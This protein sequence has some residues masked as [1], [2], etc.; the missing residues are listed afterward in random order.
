MAHI[1]RDVPLYTPALTTDGAS[2]CG[3]DADVDD[4]AGGSDSR[5]NAPKPPA[6]CCTLGGVGAMVALSMLKK[7]P[8]T[9]DS[10]ELVPMVATIDAQPY[11]EHLEL[12][13]SGTVVPYREIRVAAEISGNIIKKYPESG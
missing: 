2:G 8:E 5:G 1:E 3:S 10:K 12:N 4:V 6:D 13:L 7:P 9:Q 11:T